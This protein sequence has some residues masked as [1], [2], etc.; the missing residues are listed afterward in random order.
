MEISIAPTMIPTPR[1]APIN[2]RTPGERSGPDCR[3][4]AG[5]PRHARDAAEPAKTAVP[6]R[7]RPT[8]IAQRGRRRG[9][10]DHSR[11]QR[12]TEDPG[13]VDSDGVH[14]EGGL[15]QLRPGNEARPEASH[16]GTEWRCGQARDQARHGH[17]CNRGV[18]RRQRNEGPE[19]HRIDHGHDQDHRGLPDPIDHATLYRQRSGRGQGVAGEDQAGGRERAGRSLHKQDRRERLRGDR[20]PADRHSGERRRHPG[21][22]EH[23]PVGNR[24]HPAP[25]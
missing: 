22:S 18:R 17:R 16:R 9:G 7:L 20:Q 11:S 25:G 2:T 21:S 5:A 4:C 15:S 12:R 24:K 6:S 3:S 8:H 23:A 14:G 1:A 10:R 19:R 13:D